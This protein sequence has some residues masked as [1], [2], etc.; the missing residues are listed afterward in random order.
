MKRMEDYIDSVYSN[1]GVIVTQ[2]G[3]HT[4]K[5]LFYIF[6]DMIH[7]RVFKSTKKITFL[8][9]TSQVRGVRILL[10]YDIKS[11]KG[12]KSENFI[13]NP[14]SISNNRD[15]HD[16]VFKKFFKE[17]NNIII[18]DLAEEDIKFK[19]FIL[20]WVLFMENEIKKLHLNLLKRIKLY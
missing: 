19:E 12:E 10:A 8:L 15:Y 6:P 4:V 2:D 13:I 20:K 7:N 18:D 3:G 9:T 14:L 1:Y 16:F 11:I 5:Y 17:N